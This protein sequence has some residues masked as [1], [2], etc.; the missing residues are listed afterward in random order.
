MLEIRIR[1]SRAER[2]QQ[3]TP[4]EVGL[5]MVNTFIMDRLPEPVRMEVVYLRVAR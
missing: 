2:V 1:T 3:L 4:T 5:L